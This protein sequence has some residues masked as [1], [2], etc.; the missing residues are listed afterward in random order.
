M[1]NDLSDYCSRHVLLKLVTTSS[2]FGKALTQLSEGTLPK[3]RHERNVP[4]A[5]KEANALT[6]P[7]VVTV[8]FQ[9][10]VIDQSTDSAGKLVGN[11]C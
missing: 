1:L 4:F 5:L 9:V 7:E 6:A 8:A 10:V 2:S 3:D 11:W